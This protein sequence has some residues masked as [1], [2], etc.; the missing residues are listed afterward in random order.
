MHESRAECALTS[1]R[2]GSTL[3]APSPVRKTAGQAVCQTT[4]NMTFAS[5]SAFEDHLRQIIESHITSENPTVYA[6]QHKAVGDVVIARDGAS[7]AMF[8]LEVKYFQLSNGRLGFGSGSGGGIQPEILIKRPAYLET[9][10]RWAIA[11]D[12][13]SGYWFVA[14]DVMVPQFVSGGVVEMT[15]QNNIRTRL[16]DDHPSID[17][18]QL[19][20]ELKRW[21]LILPRATTA[22]N[23]S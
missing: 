4:T 18:G 21:L 11:S 14:S 5:E 16:F 6:L 15:K 22:L 19:I 8:F 1:H 23:R 17:Q 20:Q 12:S 3:Q 7:P 10:F 2:Q 13:H 9:H